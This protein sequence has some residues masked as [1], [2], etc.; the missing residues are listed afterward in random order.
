[1][2]TPLEPREC[3]SC[4]TQFQPA[5]CYQYECESCETQRKANE[6]RRKLEKNQTAIREQIEA[7]TPHRFTLTDVAHAQFN[8]K[9]WARIQTWRPTAEK[10]WLG[11]VG[12]TGT[13]KTRMARLAGGEWLL[14]KTTSGRIP[15][16]EFVT[17]FEISEKIMAQFNETGSDKGDARGFLDRLRRVDLLLIDDLGKG[18]LTPAP[19]AEL[20]ALVDHRHAH[21]LITI[22][23]ANSTPEEI[24]ANMNKDVSEDMKAPL[25]GRLNECSQVFILK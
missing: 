20:F 13:C 22:W 5:D 17:S 11:L 12:A 7:A 14:R 21:N 18:R 4:S 19:A 23:T 25:A 10:P 16:F 1:M 24:I 3:L 2:N 8:A 15:T 6:E 9:A